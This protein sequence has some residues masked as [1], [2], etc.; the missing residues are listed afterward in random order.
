MGMDP[1]YIG[2]GKSKKPL[3]NL[4]LFGCSNDSNVDRGEV[5]LKSERKFCAVVVVLVLCYQC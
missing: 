5:E 2:I 3:L 4:D 1:V